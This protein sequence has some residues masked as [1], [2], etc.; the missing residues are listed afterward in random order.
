MQALG[1]ASKVLEITVQRG[2]LPLVADGR[3]K[4]GLRL[5]LA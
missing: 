3:Q 2:F 1:F 5:S 4:R